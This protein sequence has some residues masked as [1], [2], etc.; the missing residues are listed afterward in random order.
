MTKNKASDDVED[1]FLAAA[2]ALFIEKGFD[3]TTVREIAKA[4][5]M[6]PGSLHYRYPTKSGLLLALMR[7]GMEADLACIRA[8]VDSSN[9]PVERVRL[10][11]RAR[12]R[13][14]VS[15]DVARV[16]LFDWR[17][18]RGEA[19]EEMIRLRDGYEAF[20]KNLLKE[21][22]DTGR[23][24]PDLDLR[25]LRFLIFGTV[26]WVA[27]WYSPKRGGRTPEE[28]ADAFFEFIAYG[29]L[30]EGQARGEVKEAL[31]ALPTLVR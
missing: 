29:V 16:V 30:D 12:V 18:L 6:L 31:R 8:A 13:Y 19:L 17:S 2:A 15:K 23:L 25:L 28:I 22:A 20:W 7:R 27:L 21:A 14:L 24:R 4:A 3:A 9:D 1:R 5:G 26:N 11:L 10:A